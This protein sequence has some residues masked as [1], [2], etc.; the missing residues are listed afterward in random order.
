MRTM[1]LGDAFIAGTAL[2]HGCR[3]ATR[4][5]QHFR[6]IPGLDVLDPVVSK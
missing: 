1:T 2:A 4:N 5:V 3:L 6:W